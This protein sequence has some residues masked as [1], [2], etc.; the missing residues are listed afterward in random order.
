MVARIINEL[1]I[2]AAATLPRPSKGPKSSGMDDRPQLGSHDPDSE[3]DSLRTHREAR[4][5]ALRAAVQRGLDDAASG[6]VVD[7]DEGIEQ[8]LR[9]IREKKAAGR[10]E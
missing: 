7:L 5:T 9:G 4:L 2:A 8:V 3:G 6:R 10:H 1:R